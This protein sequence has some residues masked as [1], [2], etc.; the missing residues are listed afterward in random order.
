M[1]A[2]DGLTGVTSN[3]SIFEKAIGHSDA[4][5]DALEAFVKANPR[6]TPRR[7]TR[8]WPSPTSRRRPTPCCRPMI[9]WTA[10]TAMSA[11]EVSPYLA[12]D[13]DGTI[14][15]ARRLWKAVDRRNLMIKV[16][17]T[18]AGVPAIRALIE[19]GLN[20]NV[21]LLFSIEAYQAVAGAYLARPGG[22]RRQGP[23]HR[24]DRQR[25]RLLRQPHR[26]PD[27]QEDRGAGLGRRQGAGGQDRHRQRQS[28]PMPGTRT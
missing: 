24:Q 8:A 25:R 22:P 10:R 12:N 27:G 20:I 23:A 26:H 5:D 18:D 2:E 9:A 6:P 11:L 21:T 7:S 19:D 16:P 28:W 1:I 3:P 17:G 13:T 15:E 14:A 4:Y